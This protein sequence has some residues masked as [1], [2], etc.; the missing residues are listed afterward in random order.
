MVGAERVT[1][2]TMIFG[3]LLV[4]VMFSRARFRGDKLWGRAVAIGILAGSLESIAGWDRG[5]TQL[6]LSD[7]HWVG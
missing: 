7:R 2:I 5:N 4:I 1:A 6:R 3:R